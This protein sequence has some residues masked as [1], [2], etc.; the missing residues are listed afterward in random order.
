M[1]LLRLPL[2]WQIL[3]A[4]LAAALAGWW[5]G[6]EAEVLGVRPYAVYEFLGA[7]FLNALKMIIV[8][9]VFSSIVVGVAGVGGR[10]GLGRLGAKTLGYYLLTSLFAILVGL[11]LVN[12]FSPG[13]IDGRPAIE[14]VGL[15]EDAAAQAA[16]RVQ[17]RGIGDIADVFLSMLPPNI[18]AAAAQGQMLGIIVFSI[19]FGFFLTRINEAYAE[20]QY[21]FWQGLF[22]IMMRITDLVIRF[23]PL[24]VFGL[25]AKV[26]AG[27]QG[28]EFA[29]LVGSLAL[30]AFTVI[31][32]LAAHVL[33]TL[34]LL[35]RLVAGVNPWRHYQAMAPAL[36]TAFSTASSSA[37]LPLT[38]ECVERNAGVSNRTSSFVLPLGATVNMW[39]EP[40][41]TSA[42]RP[43]SS[44]RPTVWSSAL[45]SSSSWCW[46]PC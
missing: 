34:P 24:G 36:M 41:S 45:P 1:A 16:Q 14:V 32:A 17:D 30:F 26:V 35:L 19:L 43:C 42:W 6:T 28:P 2:H 31:A 7:L 5:S 29:Q 23:A 18:V 10:R 11:M 20:V 21:N 25:V 8:P 15:S 22:E 13:I 44:P 9:L 40:P 27:M 39:M 4:L 33:V 12:W 46:W 3:L 37:T 38:M